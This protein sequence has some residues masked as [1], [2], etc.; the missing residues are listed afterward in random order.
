MGVFSAVIPFL[1]VFF[2][3]VL[4]F[5]FMS[6]ILGADQHKAD[7]YKY[8]NP[9]LG[10]YIYNFE[11]SLGNIHLPTIDFLKKASEVTKL[12]LVSIYLVYIFW[13]F[14]QIVLLMVLLNF[15]IALISQYYED[16]MNSAEMHS[17]VMK[18]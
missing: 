6:I 8:I 18:Q 3:W 14:A 7:D 17:H 13:W 1:F 10:L 11:N 5:T 12:D 4:F 15:V 9:F 2:L 16:V